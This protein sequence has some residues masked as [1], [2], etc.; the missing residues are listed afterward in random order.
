M[1]VSRAEKAAFND[2]I[3]QYKKKIDE[4]L[5]KIKEL[6]QIKKKMPRIAAYK[7]VE[8]VLEYIRIVLLYI[9]QND[10]SVEIM[11]VKKEKALNEARKTFYKAIQV[12]ESIVGSDVDRSLTDNEEY[13]ANIYKLTPAHILKIVNCFNEVLD[14]LIDRMGAGSK[15]KW[16]FVDL[17]GRLAVMTRNLI[18]FSDTQKY[19]DP[20]TEFYRERQQL[21]AICKNN[22]KEAALKFR[23]KY[24]QSTKATTDI[25]KSIDLLSALRKIHVLFGESEEAKKIKIT[26]DAMKQKIEEQEKEEEQKKKKI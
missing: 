22:L 13:L 4:S 26:I 9:K 7:D 25:L 3:T 17:F 18:N 8:I 2:Y 14:V 19:R 21:L 11:Q 1:V 20:R 12:M 10:A 5:K 15:W 23:T 24:E 6:E 16:S